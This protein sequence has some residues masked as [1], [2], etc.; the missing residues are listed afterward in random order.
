M[1]KRLHTCYHCKKSF[2]NAIYWMDTLHFDNFDKRL[3]R[4]FC[5]P[6]CV[7][8]YNETSG[9]RDWPNRKPSDYPILQRKGPEWRIIDN[10][11]YIEYESD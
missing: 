3:I 9:A 2:F 11:D 7:Q 1:T 4:P 6:K 8:D 5:G 10:I